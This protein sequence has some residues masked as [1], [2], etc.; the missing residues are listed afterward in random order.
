MLALR[1]CPFTKLV[2]DCAQCQETLIDR[3]PFLHAQ[4]LCACF[5]N[6]LRACQVN[7]GQ[8]GHPDSAPIFRVCTLVS[9]STLDNLLVWNN[10]CTFSIIML[11]LQLTGLAAMRAE[12]VK[13]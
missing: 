9:A 10:I 3:R 13:G 4:A 5:G 2:N 1:L 11:Q 7:Q 8:G 6:A 12:H